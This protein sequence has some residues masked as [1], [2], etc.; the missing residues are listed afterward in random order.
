MVVFA[1]AG[2]GHPL[3]WMRY[4]ARIGAYLIALL[5]SVIWAVSAL[6]SLAGRFSTSAVR[7]SAT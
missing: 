2:L 4:A 5:L 1:N 7:P 6:D 3:E